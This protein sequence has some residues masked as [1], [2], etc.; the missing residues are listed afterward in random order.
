MGNQKTARLA[1]VSYAYLS[2]VTAPGGLV[3][4]PMATQHPHVAKSVWHNQSV[5]QSPARDDSHLKTHSDPDA[6]FAEQYSC[7]AS[8]IHFT[9]GLEQIANNVHML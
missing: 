7:L 8:T 5:I 3:A 9:L 1:L 4:P 2:C 6:S